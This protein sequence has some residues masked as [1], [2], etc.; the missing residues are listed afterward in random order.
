MGAGALET[1]RDG[2]R[3]SPPLSA[4]ETNNSRTL[5]YFPILEE[6]ASCLSRSVQATHPDNRC[7]ITRPW[8][9][10]AGNHGYEES[11]PRSARYHGPRRPGEGR[12]PPTDGSRGQY[13]TLW[14]RAADGR[15][16][17]RR[18]AQWHF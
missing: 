17:L 6:Y 18:R 4:L 8:L 11:S 12:G 7:Q 2:A 14:A 1:S 13:P 5:S 16:I 3:R 10:K 15:G 9:G